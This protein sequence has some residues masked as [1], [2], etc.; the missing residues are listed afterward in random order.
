MILTYSQRRSFSGRSSHCAPIVYVSVL[1]GK[2]ETDGVTEFLKENEDG[3][4]E[5]EAVDYK[6]IVILMDTLPSSRPFVEYMRISN[7]IPSAL[8][9]S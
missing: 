3:R 1:V 5:D 2:V 8:V 9:M 7:S 6:L 4:K